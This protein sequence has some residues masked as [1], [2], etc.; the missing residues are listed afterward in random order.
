MKEIIVP[1]S[2]KIGGFDYSIEM[3]PLHTLE[4]RDANRYA[5]QSSVLHRIRVSEDFS[6][7]QISASLI[8][9]LIHAVDAIYNYSALEDKEVEAIANGL[10]QVLEQLDIRLA[11]RKT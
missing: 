2:I 11:V 4:L 7:Q 5:E 10:H 9:E 3:S 8:H 6:P 1:N